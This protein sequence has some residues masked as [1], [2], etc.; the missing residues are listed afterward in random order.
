MP[1]SSTVRVGYIPEHFSTPIQFAQAKGYFTENGISVDLIPFLSGSGHLIQSLKNDEIDIA[2]GLTEAFV[3]GLADTEKDE[4]LKYQIVG[5]Y[6]N[7]PLNWAVS[8]GINRDD[9]NSLEQ[10]EG[11][12][13]G[14]SRIGSGSYVMSYV[15][16]LDQ[17][18]KKSPPFRDFP[19]CHTFEQLRKSVNNSSCDAFMWEYFTTK[20]YYD[21]P[22]ELKMI[23][24]IYTP[25]PSWVIVRNTKLSQDVTLKFT[26]GLDQGISYFN[27]N[28][29]EAIKYI[30][31]N[32]DYTE[33]DAREWIK[34]VEFNDGGCHIFVDGPNVIEKTINVLSTARVLKQGNQETLEELINR[35]A[36]TK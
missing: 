16:A 3:R 21:N 11:G 8:T 5:T 23:G 20:K 31:E 10:L 30:H 27:E 13:I 2:I 4:V 34:T 26:K 18:F 6:V 1:G 12:N 32:L 22:K 17:G 9:V 25:W 28:H 7:S 15:L 36:R 24:N 29:E 14:V 35:V 19:V 33:E